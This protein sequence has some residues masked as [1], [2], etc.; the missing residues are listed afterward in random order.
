LRAEISG[1][2]FGFYDGDTRALGGGVHAGY[3]FSPWLAIGAWLEGSGQ[4]ER[5]MER[6][7]GAYRLY[8][9]GLGPA[10]WKEK[11]LIFGD[12]SVLPK[13]TLLT[14]Q[15]TALGRGQAIPGKR[16]TTWGAA[17]AARLRLGLVLGPWRPFMFVAGSYA[18]I[19]ERVTL[20]VFPEEGV[21]LARGNVSLG[22]DCPIASARTTR[23]HR[24][25]CRIRIRVTMRRGDQ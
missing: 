4:R 9:L 11:G 20:D 10:V 25:F 23:S 8:D 21:T 24:S 5:Q 14:V 2:G 1:F 12:L 18:L 16:A 7:S 15:T 17:A 22:V 3:R 19:A 13:L 6:G